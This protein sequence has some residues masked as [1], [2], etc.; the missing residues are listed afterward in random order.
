MSDL[1]TTRLAPARSGAKQ[2]RPKSEPS[3]GG[4]NLLRPTARID[5]LL[6][7]HSARLDYWREITD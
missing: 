7:M 2:R 4:A 6:L 1:V 5:Q 3:S